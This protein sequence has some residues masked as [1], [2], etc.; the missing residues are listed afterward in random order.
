[1]EKWS[2][3]PQTRLTKKTM[4]PACVHGLKAFRFNTKLKGR[5]TW[6][7]QQT[8]DRCRFP[9]PANKYAD[10]CLGIRLAGREG[11]RSKALIYPLRDR[12]WFVQRRVWLAPSNSTSI[13][14]RW[15]ARWKHGP[16]RCHH[17]PG[18]A[19][20]FAVFTQQMNRLAYTFAENPVI[21]ILLVSFSQIGQ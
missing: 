11:F 5:W 19:C 10:F 8:N 12:T 20:W 14:R 7:R 21:P 4:M 1:M 17:G 6:F 3:L 15:N 13:V 18:F 9:R 16:R 2:F